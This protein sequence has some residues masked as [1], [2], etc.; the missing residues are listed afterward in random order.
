MQDLPKWIWPLLR[1][2]RHA[3]PFI[4]GKHALPCDL[5]MRVLFLCRILKMLLGE[6]Q[7]RTLGSHWSVLSAWATK[8]G[9]LVWP[10]FLL[11]K[12][13]SFSLYGTLVDQIIKL[14]D[15]LSSSHLFFLF[16]LSWGSPPPP[17]FLLLL[18]HVLIY[19]RDFF[20]LIS[21]LYFFSHFQFEFL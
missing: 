15:W 14:Q 12:R 1:P 21:S 20:K 18:C 2:P 4:R 13:C 9:S 6:H 3:S 17:P 7:G 16:S 11:L 19:G 5:L 8:S 10:H